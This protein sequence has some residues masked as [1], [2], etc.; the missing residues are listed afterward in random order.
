MAQ[1]ITTTNCREKISA[2]LCSL[3][4]EQKAAVTFAICTALKNFTVDCDDI[5]ECETLTSLSEF[6]VTD[7][8]V[9]ITY[10][11]EKGEESV[12]CFTIPP[13]EGGDFVLTADNGLTASTDTN[14]QLGGDLIQNTIVTSNGF[15]L[16][17]SGLK[18]YDNGTAQL[19]SY[20]SGTITG[21]P[22]FLAAFDSAGNIIETSTIVGG[23]NRF[24]VATEDDTA[25]QTRLFDQ[26]NNTFSFINGIMGIGTST[27]NAA[28]RL[29]VEET[30]RFAAELAENTRDVSSSATGGVGI[31]GRFIIT[32][33]AAVTQASLLV[34]GLYGELAFSNSGDWAYTGGAFYPTVAG[35]NG[36]LTM[37]NGT[38]NLS[39]G[40][41]PLSGGTYQLNVAGP[42]N[43][44]KFASVRAMFPVQTP[45]ETAYSGTITNYYGVYIDDHNNGLYK[46]QI[47]NKY[48]VYQ[49]GT[50][51]SNVFNGKMFTP[52]LQN[53]ANDAA[54]AI[55]GIAVGQ[56][57]R[58]G[59][60]VQVRVS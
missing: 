34:V 17:L 54:A 47:T 49:P 13:S 12:R 28:S 38:G 25:T 30:T 48:G 8:Q 33:G 58:N 31:D 4:C 39:G 19:T 24:A 55:G 29:T 52:N 46:N 51:E 53:F 7:D 41:I 57:Y 15:D 26:N 11:D 22:A 44:D 23:N 56:Q 5:K 14:V 40:S 42:G 1:V 45:G 36:V 37:F 16:T 18:L 59:S 35:L 60:V 3:P 27:P 20:G 2:I 32:G 9:C 50:L 10:I 6:T 43:I 21:T